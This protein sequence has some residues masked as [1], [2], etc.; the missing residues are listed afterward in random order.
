MYL[1]IR[2]LCVFFISVCGLSVGLSD[3]TV[4]SASW[5]ATACV[6]KLD[7]S[8]H[9][10][11]TLSGHQA[12]VWSAIQLPSGDIVTGSADKTI[13]VWDR[14]GHFQR[15][16][17]GMIFGMFLIV[18]YAKCNRYTVKVCTLMLL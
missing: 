16:L 9:P 1:P 2:E 13:R 18:R 15:T 14:D 11:L 5:D 8:T 7:G 10:T 4:L 17:A 3:R 12:A 6:W